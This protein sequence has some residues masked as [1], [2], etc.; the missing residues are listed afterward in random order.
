MVVITIQIKYK[1]MAIE[2][3]WRE[4]LESNFPSKKSRI[5]KSI[6][7]PKSSGSVGMLNPTPK[8]ESCRLYDSGVRKTMSKISLSRAINE[9]RMIK[10]AAGKIVN[11]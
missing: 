5:V 11:Q 4:T 3:G 6:I 7:T 2:T 1:I 8:S 9:S 10:T